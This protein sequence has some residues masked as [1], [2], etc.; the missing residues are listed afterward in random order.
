MH[1]FSSNGLQLQLADSCNLLMEFSSDARRLVCTWGS[2]ANVHDVHHGALEASIVPDGEDL[3]SA[4]S[5]AERARFRD[6]CSL[7][8]RG[9]SRALHRVDA[10]SSLT[11]ARG[12]VNRWQAASWLGAIS[13]T[14]NRAITRLRSIVLESRCR[15]ASRV[16]IGREPHRA[17][18]SPRPGAMI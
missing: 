5:S 11:A 17:A 15:R 7:D 10:A 14:L 16:A 12:G 4:T 8:S 9:W 6:V 1:F 18:A 3:G 2:H 13:S